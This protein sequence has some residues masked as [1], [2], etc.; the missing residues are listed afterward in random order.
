MWLVAGLGNPGT[1]YSKTRHNIGFLV[2]EEIALRAGLTFKREEDL[3]IARG[4]IRDTDIILIEPLTFMNLSGTAIKKAIERFNLSPENLIVIHDDIDM[5]TGRLRIR[6]R[7]SSGGHRGVESIIS[8]IGS[9]EFIRVK[10]GIGRGK[11]MPVEEY[12]LSKFRKEEIPL[13]QDA[14]SRAADSV[15][16]IVTEGVDKAMNKF[17]KP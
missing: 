13:I 15:L 17:N 14:V 6:K 1:K 4:S 3:R 5:E 12:V 11:G 7:G 16:C 2:I 9:Q 10:I 8:S